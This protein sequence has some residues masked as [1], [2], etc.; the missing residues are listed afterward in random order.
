M[1]GQSYNWHDAV[2]YTLSNLM[3]YRVACLCCARVG[4]S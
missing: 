3:Q 1:S 4:A 2:I